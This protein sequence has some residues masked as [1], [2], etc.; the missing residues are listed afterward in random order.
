MRVILTGGAGFIG[1]EVEK[2]L[3]AAGHQ[4]LC[5]DR[6]Y[7]LGDGTHYPVEVAGKEAQQLIGDFQ[8][9]ALIHAGT[10]SA[11]AYRREFR[12]SFDEDYRAAHVL[13]QTLEKFSECRLIAFSSSYV[14]SGLSPTAEVDEEAPLRS[15]HPFGVAKSFFEQYFLRTHPSSVIFRLSSVFGPGQAQHPNAVTQMIREAKE[16]GQVTVWGEGARMM[17]YV[18]IGDV[19][20]AVETA[21]TLP[22][23]TY[24][25]GGSEYVSVAA[26]AAAITEAT[27]ARVEFLR[28][29]QE[30]ESLPFMRTDRITAAGWKATPLTQSLSRYIGIQ[31]KQTV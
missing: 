26:V 13:V 15:S 28:E 29:K 31:E 7:A 12:K 27:A 24:N 10:H 2:W 4:Y 11:E 5:V 19:V 17:Q 30:G 22:A 1:G 16:E 6:Q 18:W 21:L 25:L 20:A 14:Y 3:M 8:P 9:D 23:G